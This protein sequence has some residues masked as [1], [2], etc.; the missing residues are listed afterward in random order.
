MCAEHF[1]SVQH[2]NA[3][4]DSEDDVVT[5][6]LK[7]ISGLLGICFEDAV[8]SGGDHENCDVRYAAL[9]FKALKQGRKGGVSKVFHLSIPDVNQ[10]LVSP[11][12]RLG[13]CRDIRARP[14]AAWVP[15]VRTAYLVTILRVATDDVVD[16]LILYAVVIDERLLSKMDIIGPLDRC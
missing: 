15:N 9:N 3:L 6:R 13:E 4:L 7:V 1:S 14:S 10:I 5:G 11:G 12:I 8:R 2:C 16:E